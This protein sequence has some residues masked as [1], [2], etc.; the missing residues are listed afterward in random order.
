MR[1]KTLQLIIVHNNFVSIIIIDY[2]CV[3][4]YVL[5]ASS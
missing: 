2:V 3:R 4:L 1:E 5:P